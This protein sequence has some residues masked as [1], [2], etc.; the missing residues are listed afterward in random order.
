MHVTST[1]I[2]S[3]YKYRKVYLWTST[4]IFDVTIST[5]FSSWNCSRSL[6]GNLVPFWSALFN[7]HMIMTHWVT[8]FRWYEIVSVSTLMA[9]ICYNKQRFSHVFFVQCIIPFQGQPLVVGRFA[10][11]RECKTSHSLSV[12]SP[13]SSSSLSLSFH[14]LSSSNDGAVPMIPGWVKPGNRT[15]AMHIICEQREYEMHSIHFLI[16]WYVRRV[17]IYSFKVPNR[18]GCT[19]KMVSQKTPSIFSVKCCCV[20]PFISRKRTQ[21]QYFNY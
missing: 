8:T 2:C 7:L 16:T 14:M 1:E 3:I 10:N 11:G 12:W 6:P 4:E 19:R 21:V 18:F 5:I 17:G 15:P 9:N 20:T 13:F